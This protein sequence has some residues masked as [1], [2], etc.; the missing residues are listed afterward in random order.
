MSVKKFKIFDNVVI[1]TGGHK[2]KIGRI[3]KIKNGRAFFENILFEK[4]IKKDKN[5]KNNETIKRRS[6]DVSNLSHI[7]PEGVWSK[8]KIEKKGKNIERYYSKGG[9]RVIG[10]LDTIKI[11]QENKK[12]RKKN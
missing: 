11:Y 8:I 1:T 12:N 4:V 6:I 10:D 5:G 7:T 2:G 9:K 3:L